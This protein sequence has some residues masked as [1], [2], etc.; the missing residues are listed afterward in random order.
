MQNTSLILPE[1]NKYLA[2]GYVGDFPPGMKQNTPL[3]NWIW[4]DIM[5][6]TG[7]AYS[8]AKD[9]MQITKAHLSLSNTHLDTIFKKSHRTYTYDGE[10]YY[11]MAWQVKKFKEYRTTIHYKY[12]VIAG[13]SCYI[14][15]NTKTN[16]AIVVLKNN[17][18]WKDEIGHNILLRL[19]KNK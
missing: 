4:S 1:N 12:G 9:L 7:G 3:N 5:I 17:F 15:M 16:D 6:G 19:D 11:T 14:G 10:L 8:T 13:F 2:T 18:N